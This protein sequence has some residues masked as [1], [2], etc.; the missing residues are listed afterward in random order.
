MS[1]AINVVLI[2]IFIIFLAIYTLYVYES[3]RK[4]KW[5]FAPYVQPPPG[6][7]GEAWRPGGDPTPFTQD[8]IDERVQ[9]FTAPSVCPKQCP[10]SDL[11]TLLNG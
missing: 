6:D 11:F 4:R 5:L 3:Y 9:A 7:D 1:R 8:Q 10:S 2:V